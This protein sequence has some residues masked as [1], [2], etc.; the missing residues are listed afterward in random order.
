MSG[1]PDE[2]EHSKQQNSFH[3]FLIKYIRFCPE[4][5]DLFKFSTILTLVRLRIIAKNR[6]S[7]YGIS[8]MPIGGFG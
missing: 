5:V 8:Q 4:P 7:F 3:D 2:E 6:M 1:Y